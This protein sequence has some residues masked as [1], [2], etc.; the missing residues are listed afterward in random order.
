MEAVFYSI[1]GLAFF[2]AGLV[3]LVEAC[4]R[5]GAL[6]EAERLR[7]YIEALERAARDEAAS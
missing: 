7:P 1:V 3:L 2:C 4:R 5:A 6:A